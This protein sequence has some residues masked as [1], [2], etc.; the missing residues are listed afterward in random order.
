[1][2]VQSNE[3]RVVDVNGDINGV[4][5]PLPTSAATAAV[6]EMEAAVESRFLRPMPPIAAPPPPQPTAATARMLTFGMDRL[7]STS[8]SP[9]KESE[10][11]EEEGEIENDEEGRSILVNLI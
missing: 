1:M 11:D 3:C 9:D 10:E 5:E 2:Y 6:P 8:K 4:C 7:L